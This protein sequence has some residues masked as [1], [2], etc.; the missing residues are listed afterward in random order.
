MPGLRHSVL[1]C[2]SASCLVSEV[3]MFWS[4]FP[5]TL[6][7]IVMINSV[8]VNIDFSNR[9]GG[10][11]AP[12]FLESLDSQGFGVNWHILTSTLYASF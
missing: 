4:N 5:V 1:N 6:S 3:K 11:I 9:K 12:D 8:V 2:L 10:L 7:R